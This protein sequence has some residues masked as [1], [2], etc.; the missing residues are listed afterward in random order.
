MEELFALKSTRLPCYIGSCLL[1]L[2]KI[3]K[4]LIY[5]CVYDRNDS[6]LHLGK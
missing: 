5:S 4:L 2:F 1:K 3:F 6:I